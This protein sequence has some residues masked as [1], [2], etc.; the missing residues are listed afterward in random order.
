MNVT[1][2][3]TKKVKNKDWWFLASREK[4][5]RRTSSLRKIGGRPKKRSLKRSYFDSVYIKQCNLGRDLEWWIYP[6][7][8]SFFSFFLCIATDRQVAEFILINLWFLNYPWRRQ[9]VKSKDFFGVIPVYK[10]CGWRF[11][12][13]VVTQSITVTTPLMWVL[14]VSLKLS[15]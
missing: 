9:K 2:F 15:L 4:L 3:N 13:R 7:E 8:D 1:A 6:G 11:E 10:S 12:C 14:S 5:W